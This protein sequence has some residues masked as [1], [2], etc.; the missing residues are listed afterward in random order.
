[1]STTPLPSDPLTDQQVERMLHGY[2]RSR[3]PAEFVSPVA[4]PTL[5]VGP[6]KSLLARS[7]WVLAI[8]VAVVVC[9]LGFLAAQGRSSHATATGDLN[10]ATASPMKQPHLKP[11]PAK[12]P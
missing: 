1:M 3:M 8:C 12:L 10:R 5:T 9:A 4:A 6:Q 11:A 7:R 2:F